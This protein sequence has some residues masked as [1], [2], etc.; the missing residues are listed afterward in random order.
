MRYSV[1]FQSMYKMCNAQIM[2]AYLS[3]HLSFMLEALK[4]H[5]S[6]YMKIHNKLLLSYSAVK[7]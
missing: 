3:P 5:S 4:I 1:I 6:S 7:H 2:V